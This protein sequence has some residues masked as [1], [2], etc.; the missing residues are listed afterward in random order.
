MQF[1]TDSNGKKVSVILPVKEYIKMIDE[2][3]DKKDIELYD[4]AKKRKLEMIP[5]EDA[6]KIVEARRNKNNEV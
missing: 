6:F 5:M 2:L 3:E 1:I 4:N